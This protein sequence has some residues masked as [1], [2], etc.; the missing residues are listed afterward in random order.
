MP[1]SKPDSNSL[2]PSHPE[3]AEIIPGGRVLA[4]MEHGIP[5]QD[6]FLDNP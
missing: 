1:S 3:F 4:A 5:G 6:N 2:I